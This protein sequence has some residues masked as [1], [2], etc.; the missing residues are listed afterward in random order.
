[1][2]TYDHPGASAPVS[3]LI[4]KVRAVKRMTLTA[5]SSSPDET[6]DTPFLT[7]WNTTA[8]DGVVATNDL[9]FGTILRIPEYFG[10]REF[11]VEDRMNQRYTDDAFLDIWFPSKHEAAHFGIKHSANIEIIGRNI[12]AE[13]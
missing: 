10:D 9:P 8:H 12:V 11:I 2:A 13:K 7:A 1:V 5:Y 3:P 4:R 6:D